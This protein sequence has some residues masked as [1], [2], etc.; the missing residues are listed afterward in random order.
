MNK[1]GGGGYAAGCCAGLVVIV[2]AAAA[3]FLP[4]STVYRGV[5]VTGIL[6]F[7]VIVSNEVVDVVVI[8]ASIAVSNEGT[9]A[10]SKTSWMN[11]LSG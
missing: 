5:V 11:S 6:F 8:D 1:S 2:V 9:H 10:G 7:A 3:W 4:V